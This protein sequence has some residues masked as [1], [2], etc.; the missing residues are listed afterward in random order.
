MSD[1]I[2]SSYPKSFSRV[3]K[4][5]SIENIFINKS[6]QEELRNAL[7]LSQKRFYLYMYIIMLYL[8]SF[9]LATYVS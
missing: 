1:T 9:F 8:F 6:G 4:I 5:Q 7:H 3:P 2:I